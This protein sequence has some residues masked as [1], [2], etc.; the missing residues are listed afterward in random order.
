[1]NELCSLKVKHWCSWGFFGMDKYFQQRFVTLS[2]R[3]IFLLKGD[4]LLG[5]RACSFLAGETFS[6]PLDL[7][8][9]CHYL[10]VPTRGF[11]LPSSRST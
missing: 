3:G 8:V 2:K 11:L 6:A 5:V 4:N 9:K 7:L 10:R 1:M